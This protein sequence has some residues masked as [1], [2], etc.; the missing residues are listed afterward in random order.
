MFGHRGPGRRSGAAIG[1]WRLALCLWFAALPALAQTD[2]MPPMSMPSMPPATAAPSS[3]PHASM[4]WAADTRF[5]LE[6]A[7]G[8][9]VADSDFRG[10]FLLLQVVRGACGQPCRNRADDVR[11]ALGDLAALGRRVRFVQVSA[12]ATGPDALKGSP[13]GIEGL[14]VGHGV[15]P[16]DT[17]PDGALLLDD[18][19]PSS[20]RCGGP[21]QPCHAACASS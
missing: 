6:N 9:R 4:T 8:A 19:A 15:A 21:G 7:K 20:N 14:L 5:V 3:I 12:Q 1:I 16:H 18:E 11:G 13:A 17:G 10:R 2:G